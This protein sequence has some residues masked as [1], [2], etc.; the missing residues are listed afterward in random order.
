MTC[1]LLL[2]KLVGII[3]LKVTSNF[4]YIVIS[5]FRKIYNGLKEGLPLKRNFH[6]DQWGPVSSVSRLGVVVITHH[7]IQSHEPEDECSSDVISR[8]LKNPSLFE[9]VLGENSVGVIVS[10]VANCIRKKSLGVSIKNT[11][12][13][14]VYTKTR[15]SLYNLNKWLNVLPNHNYSKLHFA[16][17]HDKIKGSDSYSCILSSTRSNLSRKHN[18]ED[19]RVYCS[20]G[21]LYSRLFSYSLRSFSTVNHTSNL[22]DKLLSKFQYISSEKEDCSDLLEVGLKTALKAN[23]DYIILINPRAMNLSEHLLTETIQ[24]LADENENCQVDFVLGITKPCSRSLRTDIDVNTNQRKLSNGLYLFGLKGQHHIMSNIK[25][26][27]ANLEWSSINAADILYRN[28]YHSLRNKNLVCL[29]ERLE[30]VSEPLDLINVQQ[31]TGL[32]CENVL[33]DSVT[34]IIPMGYGH[35]DDC[36]DSEDIELVD[37]KFS[38]SLAYTIEL[39]V[40]NASGKRQIEVIIIDSSPSKLSQTDKLLNSSTAHPIVTEYLHDIVHPRCMVNVQLYHYDPSVTSILTPS[41]GELIR[42]AID[43]YANGSMLVILEPGVQLPVNWDSAVYYTLQRP[44]V[45][46]GCF[47]YRLHLDDKYIHQKSVLWALSC[48]LGSWIVNVQTNWSGVPIAGQ[49]HFIYSHY[50]KCING[51]PRSCRAFHAIDLALK[52]HQY[53]GDVICTRSRTSAAGVPADYALRHGVYC[54]VLYTI[55]L[56]IARYLGATEVQLKWALEKFPSLS[57]VQIMGK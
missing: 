42:Y 22:K 16:N 34:V 6:G 11:D 18:L 27:C 45:G 1:I 30:E 9:R 25:S 19:P 13:I 5:C 57:N 48:W 3:V 26:I 53:L 21:Q 24:L 17:N 12:L 28:I 46:M 50:L 56:G 31:S 43:Q 54:T 2:T 49:P 4:L 8:S 7:H 36:V 55:L 15:N 14:L 39:V 33:N 51:Y 41:R 52:S 35:P 20:Y 37:V 29:R 32:L 10:W 23:L 38:K 44:G 47:A 40:H